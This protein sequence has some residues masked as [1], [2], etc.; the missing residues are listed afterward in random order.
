MLRLR[1]SEGEI[2]WQIDRLID[3]LVDR[4]IGRQIDKKGRKTVRKKQD[5]KGTRVDSWMQNIDFEKNTPNTTHSKAPFLAASE[6]YWRLL[7]SLLIA[8]RTKA[9]H[10]NA[11]RIQSY[12]N[13]LLFSVRSKLEPPRWLLLLVSLCA[14]L[15]ASLTLGFRLLWVAEAWRTALTW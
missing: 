13:L 14:D 1:V 3:R 7:A 15:P 6:A 2:D 9:R 8:T 11:Q 10:R 4:L 12:I 5:E